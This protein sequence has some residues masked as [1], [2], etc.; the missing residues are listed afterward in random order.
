M[1]VQAS[2]GRTP[3]T[4]CVHAAGCLGPALGHRLLDGLWLAFLV[5]L[6]GL[7]VLIR[8]LALVIFARLAGRF[9]VD[10]VFGDPAERLVVVAGRVA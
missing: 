8:L 7:L 6:T 3:A 1:D 2:Q 9:N 4:M 5:V 10:V